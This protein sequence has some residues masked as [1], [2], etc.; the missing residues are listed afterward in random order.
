LSNL[1]LLREFRMLMSRSMS[2]RNAGGA[3]EGWQLPLFADE[4]DDDQTAALTAT[5]KASVTRES[6]RVHGSQP[7][8]RLGRCG[9]KGGPEDSLLRASAHDLRGAR[10]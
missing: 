6:L 7:G 1:T 10:P 5:P 3:M 2:V 9:R 4:S 8:I